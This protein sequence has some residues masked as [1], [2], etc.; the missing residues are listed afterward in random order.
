ME[1]PLPRT[2]N[3]NFH[4]IRF[5]VVL[6]NCVRFAS[7]KF[8]HGVVAQVQRIGSLKI[9]HS[10]ERNHAIDGSFVGGQAQRKLTAG[11]MP[12]N[13]QLFQVELKSGMFLL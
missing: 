7:E 4:G 5:A 11:R 3:T 13:H 12:H 10:G 1:Q 2:R 9:D 8:R 6:G